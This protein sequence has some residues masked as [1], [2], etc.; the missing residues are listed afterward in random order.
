MSNDSFISKKYIIT[1]RNEEQ[2]KM[3]ESLLQRIDY[4]CRVGSSRELKIF[5]DGDGA[6]S[7]KIESEDGTDLISYDDDFDKGYGII[8]CGYNNEPYFWDLG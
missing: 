4:L 3:F 6:V 7:L 8:R 2:L 1:A 5:I